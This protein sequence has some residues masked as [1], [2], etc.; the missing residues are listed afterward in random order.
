MSID[1]LRNDIKQ[2]IKSDNFNVNKLNKILD[3]ISKYVDSPIFVQN[4]ASIVDILIKDRNNNNKFDV[5]DLQLLSKNIECVSSL[6]SS[7]LFMIC[8][9]PNLKLQYNQG[10]TEELI[11]KILAYIFLVIVPVRINRPLT[12]E[13]KETILN[14]SLVIHQ[15]LISSQMI[16]ILLSQIHSQLKSKKKC[17]CMFGATDNDQLPNK[18]VIT[19]LNLEAAVENIKNNPGKIIEKK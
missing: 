4:I 19:K 1:T 9:V 3:P 15:L 2:I 8:S 5:N 12:L 6:T 17:N 14:L 11:F 10:A 18:M 16:P 13:E 7:I